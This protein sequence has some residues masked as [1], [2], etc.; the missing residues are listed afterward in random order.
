MQRHIHTHTQKYSQ[1]YMHRYI[2]AQ[3][4]WNYLRPNFLEATSHCSRFTHLFMHLVE[5]KMSH[6]QFIPDA[7]SCPVKE[8][9]SVRRGRL[10]VPLIVLQQLWVSEWSCVSVLVNETHREDYGMNFFLNGKTE[11]QQTGSFG[12]WAFPP[13]WYSH[14]AAWS[15][16]CLPFI[17]E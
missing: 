10:C 15:C 12:L 4:F 6:K 5:V 13:A 9:F 14:G 8:L 16:S 11:P 17:M 2:F 1:N 3:Y 7:N